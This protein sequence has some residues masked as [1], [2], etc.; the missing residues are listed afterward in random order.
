MRNVESLTNVT[1]AI[2]KLAENVQKFRNAKNVIGKLVARVLPSTPATSVTV[3]FVTNATKI[4]EI[5]R[6][7]AVRSAITPTVLN[8]CQR[9]SSRAKAVIN[10]AMRVRLEPRLLWSKK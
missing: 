8:V 6:Q 5:R 9:Q 2:A 10:F 3:G 4:V 7:F 1:F